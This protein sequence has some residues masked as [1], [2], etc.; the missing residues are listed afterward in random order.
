M[1]DP[2]SL[3]VSGTSILISGTVAWLTLLRR[4]RV[5]MTKPTIVCFG[6]VSGDQKTIP[7]VFLRTLLY[8]TAKRGII[9]ENMFV[10]VYHDNSC[11]TF[12]IWAYRDKDLVRGSGVYVGMEG[13]ALEH[14]FHPLE[15]SNF[16]FSPGNYLIEVFALTVGSKRSR[17]LAKI[18]LSLTD[19]EA[20][21]I[22]AREEGFVWFDWEPNSR[23]YVPQL[24][25]RPQKS[26]DSSLLEKLLLGYDGRNKT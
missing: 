17:K 3:A 25:T 2:I 26:S 14:H 19:Q 9:V 20:S 4:G 6:T 11:Q 10:N 15:D 5:Q 16:I 18:S 13:L 7:K 24:L 23:S 1:A 22:E 12:S 8:C 21:L